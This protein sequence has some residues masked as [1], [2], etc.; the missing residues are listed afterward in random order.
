MRDLHGNILNPFSFTFSFWKDF[1]GEEEKEKR[2]I[3]DESA[4]KSYSILT[5]CCCF[6]W[7]ASQESFVI[8]FPFCPYLVPA[9]FFSTGNGPAEL[10]MT[11]GKTS[12]HWRDWRRISAENHSNRRGLVLF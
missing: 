2:E 9:V 7:L 11:D 10:C 1:I 12:L 3:R 8:S 5:G 6:R 4:R